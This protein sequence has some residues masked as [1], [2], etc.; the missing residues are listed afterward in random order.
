MVVV[1]SPDQDLCIR[2]DSRP[3]DSRK[4]APEAIIGLLAEGAYVNE[5]LL[6]ESKNQTSICASLIAESS[7][8]DCSCAEVLFYC[9]NAAAERSAVD[10]TPQHFPELLCFPLHLAVVQYVR[11][12]IY[13]F[14]KQFSKIFW[15]LSE[16]PRGSTPTFSNSSPRATYPRIFPAS[17]PLFTPAAK[18]WSLTFNV[19]PTPQPPTSPY[20]PIFIP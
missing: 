19:T 11:I 20:I 12:L 6:C 9:Y 16:G 1:G 18:R 4:G 13:F 3:I 2:D 14:K 10:R 7:F 8:T 15:A 5:T 17:P